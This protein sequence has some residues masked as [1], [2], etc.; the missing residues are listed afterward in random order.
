MSSEERS[1]LRAALEHQ[2][3]VRPDQTA[4]DLAAALRRVGFDVDKGRVN[5][6]LYRYGQ[7]FTNDGAVPP[8]WRVA[9]GVADESEA[10]RA[11][12]RV[13]GILLRNWKVFEDVTVQIR[14]ITLL[15]GENSAGKSSVIQ[16]LL[17]MRDSWGFGDL[18][19]GGRHGWFE[20]V[21]HR[22]E[23]DRTMSLAALWG[24]GALGADESLLVGMTAT[25]DGDYD[26]S[27]DGHAVRGF[28][29]SQGADSLIL[30]RYDEFEG[31]RE[32]L[33]AAYRID[34]DQVSANQ[35]PSTE[36]LVW[37]RS[38]SRGFPDV[39]QVASEEVDPRGAFTLR[40]LREV[41]SGAGDLFASIEYVPP[42]RLLP[43]RDLQMGTA[44]KDTPAL[45]LLAR[46]D[47]LRTEVQ[48]WLVRFE[49][50]Y[51]L[52]HVQ[53]GGEGDDAEFTLT[54]SRG[55]EAESVQLADV[56]FGLSQLLPIVTLLL[57]SRE[58]TIL[59]EE[60]E[61]HVHPRLQSVLADLLI[62]SAQDYGN[63][64]IVET[65][66]EPMLL[67]LQR[68]VAEGRVDHESLS[69]VHVQRHGLASTVTEVPVRADGQLDYVWPGGFF[70]DRMDD[71]VAILDPRPED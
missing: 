5:S 66:S 42:A 38:D 4:R 55:A 44:A 35:E 71:L 57:H 52:S 60:P 39:D 16:G 62:T 18:Q 50:P 11:Q 65:H 22:H 40:Q 68:R 37:I 28:V 12:H 64:L 46:S 45:A 54:L 67:R 23:V 15:F 3:A 59:L 2:V 30:R 9:A 51:E 14:D 56:G 63:R 48:E 6:V 25:S 17:L 43:P 31:D 7:V 61:A 58:L 27:E 21:V 69:I 20:H 70:D 1:A 26:F 32:P 33:W 10:P 53:H 34:D 19:L 49:V 29:C 8:H 47:E 36:G 41:I 24:D 13:A